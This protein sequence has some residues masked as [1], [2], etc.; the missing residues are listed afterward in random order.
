MARRDLILGLLVAT[1]AGCNAAQ[2]AEPEPRPVVDLSPAALSVSQQDS[3]DQ[4]QA[5]KD[6]GDYEEALALFREI[7]ADNPVA[8]DALVGIGDVYLA[9]GLWDRAEPAFARAAKLEPRNFDAQYGHGVTLQ[10]LDRFV[11]AVRAY[12][13]ALTIDPD[14]LGAN[15]NLA[16]TYLQMGRP[17]SAL[18]FAQRGADLS[19]G[20]APPHI[21]LA[22]TLQL[23]GNGEAAL[24]QYITAAELMEQP[25]PQLMENIIYLLSQQRRYLEVANAAR[26]LIRIDPTTESWERLGWAEFRL[27]NYGESSKA[28][29]TAVQFEERNW[30]AVNG[31][32]VTALNTW[33]LSDKQDFD[34]HQDARSAFRNSLSINPDQPKVITLLLRYNL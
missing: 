30:R 31:V 19:E 20:T 18:V 24:E 3:L 1:L 5:A 23:L 21:T 29:R 34:A 14:S 9:E 22:A 17:K 13:R 26:Q 27:G 8:T 11:E 25:S 12:H 28:Y 6:S 2:Q 15:L 16:T 7:L 32:G 4:A 33:L 10:M